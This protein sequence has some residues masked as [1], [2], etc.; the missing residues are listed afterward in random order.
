MEV[1]SFPDVRKVGLTTAC[2]M[3][4]QKKVHNFSNILSTVKWGLLADNATGSQPQQDVN[5]QVLDLLRSPSPFLDNDV[6]MYNSFKYN[7]PMD[8]L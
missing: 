7:T 1:H 8:I 6:A 3:L 2:W 5:T 4:S